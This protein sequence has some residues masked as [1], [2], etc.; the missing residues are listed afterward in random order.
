MTEDILLQLY[1]VFGSNL[2][3]ALDLIDK[4]AIN[5][6]IAETS[7]QEFFQVRGSSDVTYLIL[8][9][10]WRCSCSA[11]FQVKII[12]KYEK[13]FFFN[14]MILPALKISEVLPKYQTFKALFPCFMDKTKLEFWQ[15]T[16]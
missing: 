6:I 8:P 9:S 11:W 1:S 4:G 7:K 16:Y 14:P 13:V 15:I 2:R 5:K 3:S 10:S 12:N